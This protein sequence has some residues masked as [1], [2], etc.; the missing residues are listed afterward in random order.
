MF[1]GSHNVPRDWVKVVSL[2]LDPIVVIVLGLET[3]AL[4]P[5]GSLLFIFLNSSRV[6]G[7]SS[8]NICLDHILSLKLTHVVNHLAI[9]V[10]IMTWFCRGWTNIPQVCLV[11]LRWWLH[12]HCSVSEWCS[13][14][15]HEVRRWIITTSRHRGSTCSPRYSFFHTWYMSWHRGRPEGPVQLGP[16]RFI[17]PSNEAIIRHSAL[18]ILWE[19]T[20]AKK[21]KIGILE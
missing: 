12:W 20:K 8:G 5:A 13:R 2:M 9:E 16:I 3:G 6:A 11:W 21:L 4:I 15:P 17:Y 18:L 14:I 10:R 7:S 19:T 1:P